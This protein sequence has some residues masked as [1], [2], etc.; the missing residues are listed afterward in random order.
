MQGSDAAMLPGCAIDATADDVVDERLIDR[1]VQH[2]RMVVVNMVHKGA[3]DVGNYVLE[4]FFHGDI[5]R[6]VSRSPF[7]CASFRLLSERCG[8][9]ELPISKS[10]LHN[11]VGIAVMLRALPENAAFRLLPPS[12]QTILLPLRE[13]GAVEVAARRAVSEGLSVRELRRSIHKPPPPNTSRLRE[14]PPIVQ[15]TEEIIRL[16]NRGRAHFTLTCI[17]RLS[18]KD[19]ARAHQAAL[20]ALTKLSELVE[21][22][23]VRVPTASPTL[24]EE[25]DPPPGVIESRRNTG[26]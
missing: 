24:A 4:H 6:V 1:A 12:H 16:L 26:T 11:A 7:K 15:M 18:D 23:E 13:P 20:E 14:R 2:I 9:Q 5:E 22:L 25:P 21:K 17:D 8:S 19:A 3:L 10:W